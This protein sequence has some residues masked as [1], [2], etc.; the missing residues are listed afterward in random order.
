[1]KSIFSHLIAL[2]L[3]SLN[4]FS[5]DGYIQLNTQELYNKAEYVFIQYNEEM[6][7]FEAQNGLSHDNYSVRVNF[8]QFWFNISSKSM[9]ISVDTWNDADSSNAIYCALGPFKEN[10]RIEDLTI[11]DSLSS[12]SGKLLSFN[13]GKAKKS[14]L[15]FFAEGL[16]TVKVNLNDFVSPPEGKLKFN[17]IVDTAHFNITFHGS[18]KKILRNLLKYKLPM[19]LKVN[20]KDCSDTFKVMS[21]KV[22]VM[23]ED[24]SSKVFF[25]NS[26]RLSEETAQ[27]LLAAD[28]VNPVE[29]FD[30]VVA[31]SQSYYRSV[32]CYFLME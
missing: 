16:S 19:H 6:R 30:I 31:S 10:V 17:G 11:I 29:F 26:S 32:S 25:V 15:Y 27:A 20:K 18:E 13:I 22:R 9:M 8:N 24:G 23:Y 3:Y 1:M 4:A 12:G 5:Q 14:V 7:T 28:I 21:Y 2:I